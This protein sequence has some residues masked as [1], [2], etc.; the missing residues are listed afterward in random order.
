M[1]R[2]RRAGVSS[3][4]FGGTN[5]H[6]VIEQG[7]DAGPV[8][9]G[10]SRGDD[11]GGVGQDAERVAVARRVVGRLAGRR[12]AEV[13]LADVAHTLN[14]HRAQH[15]KFATVCARDAARPWRACGRWPA[16]SRAGRRRRRMR[17]RAGRERCSCTPVRVRSGP[18]WAGGCWPTSRR[19][20]RRSPSW[21][22]S[23]SHR[24]GSRCSD[25]WP[26][27]R[28]VV[29]ID[30][31]QPVLVGVQ[32]AL[33]ALWRS[34]GVK[35]D[36][37]IGH[38]MGEVTAAV[39]A[40]ALTPA[41]GLEVI[42]TRSR[43]MARLS[44]QGAMAL[45]ELDA[46]GRRGVDRRLRRVTVAVYASPHQT[47]IAGPPDQVDAVDRG[48]G[49]AGPAGPP[50]RR[51]RGVAPPDHRSDAAR[52]ARGAGRLGA[53]AADDPDH[54]PPPTAPVRRRCFDAEHWAA[55]LRNPVRFARRSP[56]PAPTTATFIEISPHP[57]LTYAIKDTLADTHHHSIATL[58]RDTDDTLTFHTNLNATHTV[59]PPQQPHPPEPHP[60]IPTTPWHHTRHWISAAGRH[61]PTLTHHDR[62]H[63]LLGATAA[64][65]GA[66]APHMS[67]EK[68]APRR[69][70]GSPDHQIHCVA[71]L[72]GAAYCEMALAAARNALGD[73]S[74]VRDLSFGEMLLLRAIHQFPP[75]DR[76]MRPVSRG[77]SCRPTKRGSRSSARPHLH[78]VADGAAATRAMSRSAAAHPGTVIGGESGWRW[79]P[80]HRVR[81]RLHRSDPGARRGD[82][83][84]LLAEIGAPAGI[85]AEQSG[86][87]S[88]RMLDGCSDPSAHTCWSAAGAVRS[89]WAAVAVEYRP[90]AP[91]RGGPRRALLPCHGHH[92]RPRYDR[93]GPRGA[94]RK[95]EVVLESADFGWAA[96]LA[97]AWNVNDCWP[98]VVDRRVGAGRADN[99]P[100]PS[101]SP[102]MA[103]IS[104]VMPTT[105]DDLPADLAMR[106]WPVVPGVGRRT[107][108]DAEG[109]A[110]DPAAD[111]VTGVVIMTAPARR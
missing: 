40:G 34:Y 8:A 73:G 6:V 36:A 62:V 58:Q 59:R 101:A 109:L 75:S 49:R 48:G 13:A 44:G 61:R 28:P 79:P 15:A 74:E 52:T 66:R 25:V 54:R 98:T 99:R 31:I 55:N 3:F 30:R 35:P 5:A 64:P 80:G 85:L 43:L 17:A 2:P 95:G 67:R 105:S 16:A 69:C 14:H 10:R 33:T 70:H 32:L 111:G 83:A 91:P 53:A 39:V 97:T 68:S 92:G 77:S 37:V 72:P 4:G 1:R 108:R 27:A 100:P 76:S 96:A 56:P 12:R 29:G 104:S 21:S 89:R 60:P 88:T 106:W 107:G 41:D 7:L 110:R 19:S 90:T 50:G 81:S 20:P 65:G 51:R 23:S 47:V 82:S 26:A 22:R 78:A 24:S 9:S 102:G 86:W 71:A 103:L 57:L 63:P 45:L 93:G 11:V 84:A 18:G 46:G 42:A 87:A 94:G 38:S